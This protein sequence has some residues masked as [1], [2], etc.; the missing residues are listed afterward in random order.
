MTHFMEMDL[1]VPEVKEALTNNTLYPMDAF[2]G[3]SDRPI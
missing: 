1:P 3:N 2:T